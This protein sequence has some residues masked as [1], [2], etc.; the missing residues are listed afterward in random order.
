MMGADGCNH[1]LYKLIDSFNSSAEEALKCVHMHN[2]SL[3]RDNCIKLKAYSDLFL[4]GLGNHMTTTIFESISSIMIQLNADLTELQNPCK[5][6]IQT[7]ANIGLVSDDND[8]TENET[9][10]EEGDLSLDH[11]F[12]ETKFD[13][14]VGNEKAKQSLYESI[15]LP[16]SLDPSQKCRLYNGIRKACSNIIL[17]GPPGCGKTLIAQAAAC[18][19]RASFFPVKPSDVLSKYQGESERYIRGI[20]E[21]AGKA[22]RSIVFFDEFDSIALSR[23]GSDDCAQTRRLLSEIL[24]Q[25]NLLKSKRQTNEINVVVIAATNRLEDLDEAIIRRFDIK[26]YC[27][28]PDLNSRHELISR[29][30]SG[31][32]AVVDDADIH[33]IA[34]KT[35]G[36]SGCDIEDLCREA[37]MIPVRSIFHYSISST[38][39]NSSNDSGRNSLNNYNGTRGLS[40]HTTQTTSEIT[41]RPITMQDFDAAFE[42]LLHSANDAEEETGSD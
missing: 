32:D 15:I 39:T 5:M 24:L 34:T 28:S 6:Y 20:F 9:K 3:A 26:I 42:S 29:F 22:K 8:S 21:K 1:H 13:D 17:Y 18:E 25:L 27:G 40:K 33:E 16:F 41:I 12:Q 4:N 30:L 14:I 35:V 11:N 10:E 38:I 2:F 36:W 37:A 19:A 7:H 23:G 31:V